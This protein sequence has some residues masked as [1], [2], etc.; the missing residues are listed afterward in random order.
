MYQT[1]MANL[2]K[3]SDA[4]LQ[5]LKAKAHGSQLRFWLTEDA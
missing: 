4:K 2:P 5:G 1:E 3:G